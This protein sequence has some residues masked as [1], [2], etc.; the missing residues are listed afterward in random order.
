MKK[1]RFTEEQIVAILKEQEAGAPLHWIATSR[2]PIPQSWRSIGQRQ[3]LATGIK[4]KNRDASHPM[5]AMLNYA[6]VVLESTV[7]LDVLAQGY[8][9]QSG[10]LHK[11]ARNAP[12]LAL[13]LMEPLRPAID[14]AVLR[15]V[16]AQTFT[17]ADFTLQA[18][19]VVRLNPQLA[20]RVASFSAAVA[21]QQKA[22]IPEL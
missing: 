11:S 16:R 10:F 18:H 1:S 4:G 7:R 5:N 13:D 3:S 12:A 6:Y 19:G 22:A 20:R 15:F 8:D 21:A 2:H 17:P 9:P 14:A